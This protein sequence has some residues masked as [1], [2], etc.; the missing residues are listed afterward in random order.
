MKQITTL[1]LLLSI[2]VLLSA[3]AQESWAQAKAGY[4][5]QLNASC[6]ADKSIF[7]LGGGTWVTDQWGWEA[8]LMSAELRIKASDLKGRESHLLGSALYNLRPGTH[9]WY[10]YLRA[11]LGVAK[12]DAPI[13]LEPGNV[14]R[15]AFHG[16][17]GAQYFFKDHGISS[18]E[19]RTVKIQNNAGRAELQLLA[20]LGYRWSGAMPKL[21]SIKTEAPPEEIQKEPVPPPPPTP[22]PPPPVVQ[23]PA[24]PAEPVAAPEV[25]PLPSRIVLDEAV[26]HFAYCRTELDTA[27]VLDIS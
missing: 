21:A 17:V 15:L 8:D 16:G 2:P 22:Q 19:V 24:E 14:T 26:L 3:Q 1:S 11:G 12:M 13:S 18:L 7:G 27:A 23:K 10:P 20:G 9:S 5:K 4:L 6:L 25:A